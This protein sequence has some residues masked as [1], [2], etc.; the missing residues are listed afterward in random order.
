M[1][2]Q[3]FINQ[4]QRTTSDHGVMSYQVFINIYFIYKHLITHYTVVWS[5]SLY[6]INKHLITHYTVVWNRTTSDHGI[7]S[8]QVFINKI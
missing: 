8:Y 2:Y 4:I 5:S 3:V 1:S 6:F 7:M